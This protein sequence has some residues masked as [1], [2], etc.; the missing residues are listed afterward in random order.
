MLRV[1]VLSDG[2]ASSNGRAMLFP[3]IV[4]RNRLRDCDIGIRIFDT[5]EPNIADCDVLFVDSKAFRKSW[6]D[7][8]EKTLELLSEWHSRTALIWLDTTDSSSWI[9]PELL[10]VVDLYCKNQLVRDRSILLRP[11]YGHRLFA[12]YYHRTRGVDDVE[13]VWQPPVS[14]ASL[15]RRLRV[16]WNSGLADW[17]W[18]GRYRQA[19]YQRV[20][21]PMVLRFAARFTPPSAERRLDVSCRMGTTYARDSVAWQRRALHERLAHLIQTDRVSRR[22]YFAE[23]RNAKVVLSPFGWGEINYKDFETFLSG[24]I[25]MKPDMTHMETWPDFYRPDKTFIAHAWDLDDVEDRIAEVLDNYPR[26][27]DVAREGQRVYREALVGERGREAF[28][29]RVA[30]LV[31]E[32]RRHHGFA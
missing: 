31:A 9:R 11:L 22:Q 24:S 23:L 2:F 26:Y 13:P 20:R 27:L 17:S 1:H 29:T 8:G 14:D 32:A 25:L 12:D 10:P 16:S 19:L 4:H 21:L 15:L 3:L 5:V 28:C 18:A 30:G 6:A 7:G